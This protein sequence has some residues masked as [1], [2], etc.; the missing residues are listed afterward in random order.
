MAIVAA[1]ILLS[2][3]SSNIEQPDPIPKPPSESTKPHSEG[4]KIVV[5]KSNKFY[6]VHQPA[7]LSNRKDKRSNILLI[8]ADDMRADEIKYMP[9][10][11]KILAQQGFTFNEAI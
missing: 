10:T 1:S 5:P 9:K 7:K 11:Q 6:G 2:S 8:S 3:C 4:P